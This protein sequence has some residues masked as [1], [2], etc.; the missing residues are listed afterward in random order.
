MES[1]GT[2]LSTNWTDVGKRKVDVNP[3]DD[4]E[5]KPYW[6]NLAWWFQHDIQVHNHLTALAFPSLCAHYVLFTFGLSF[7]P[8]CINLGLTVV[9][10]TCLSLII[11]PPLH[12]RLIEDESSSVSQN[13]LLMFLDVYYTCKI[14]L[15]FFNSLWCGDWLSGTSCLWHYS[16]CSSITRLLSSSLASVYILAIFTMYFRG[17]GFLELILFKHIVNKFFS[18]SGNGSPQFFF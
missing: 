18:G 10:S 7:R 15:P 13:H 12:W 9:V 1:G 4:M 17:C 11:I 8:N 14:S 5:W 16:T 6:R 2:V 3:P